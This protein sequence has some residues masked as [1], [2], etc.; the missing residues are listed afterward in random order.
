MNTKFTVSTKPLQEAIDLCIIKAN[1]SPTYTKST[2][3]QIE[4]NGNVLSINHAANSILSSVM[5]KGLNEDDSYAAIMVDSMLFKQLVSTFKTPQ[6]SFEFTENALVIHTGTSV[7]SLSKMLDTSE[8]TLPVPGS[9]TETDVESA[10]EIVKS[11]WRFIKEHQMYAK[12]NS[13]VNPV[14]TYVWVGENGDV[15][16]GDYVNSIFTHSKINKFGKTCLLTDT[17]VNLFNNL[18]E[19]AKIFPHNNTYFISVSTDGYEYVSEFTPMYESDETGSYNSDIIINM[20]N[21]NTSGNGVNVNVDEI[22]TALNQAALLSKNKDSQVTFTVKENQ[23]VI[24]DNH[25]NCVIATEGINTNQFS[26]NFISSA[27]KSVI[28]NCP[29]TKISIRPT[30]NEDEIVG[31]TITSGKLTVVLAGLE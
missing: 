14:Y 3:V 15:L 17:I 30:V 28:S 13:Y 6:V 25:V 11:D 26:L 23:I 8:A 7:F 21:D 1:V 31:I 29:D 24:S 18:P 10:N 9:F 27:L 19:N 12:S 4:A 5:L 2:I 16:V 20:M 22:I